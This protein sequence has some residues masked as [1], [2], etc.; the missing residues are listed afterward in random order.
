MSKHTKQ[1]IWGKMIQAFA[2]DAT[3]EE[4]EMAVDEM[5]KAC[6]DEEPAV[7]TPAPVEPPKEPGQDEGPNPL[8]ERLAKVEAM[9]TQLVQAMQ[10]KQEPDALDALEQ[11][12]TGAPQAPATDEESATVEPEQVEEARAAADSAV[13]LGQIAALKP[14][15]AQIKDPVQRKKTSDTLAGIL[16]Q[17]VNTTPTASGAYADLYQAARQNAQAVRKAADAAADES[18]L[19]KEIAAKYNPHYKKEAK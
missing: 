11:E 18:S 17:G 13:L 19:G 4:M 9:L 14:V 2:Q 12:L 16:R 6:G 10:P 7:P 8:E 1:G 15:V 3:P 5:T